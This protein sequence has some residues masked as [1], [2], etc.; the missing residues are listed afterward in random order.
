MI[1]ATKFRSPRD[2]GKY[3]K[4]MSKKIREN[5]KITKSYFDITNANFNSNGIYYVEHTDLTQKLNDD[6]STQRAKRQEARRVER[7]SGIA[8][9]NA[10][11]GMKSGMTTQVSGVES[12]EMKAL[13]K[14][15]AELK[16]QPAQ[17]TEPTEEVKEKRSRR[18]PAEMEEARK[19]ESKSK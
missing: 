5:C 4:N 1:V 2:E 13:R 18:T 8:L 19:S 17:P 12:P 11:S 9:A 15:L 6:M 7:D 10:I 3:D 16:A 14:E